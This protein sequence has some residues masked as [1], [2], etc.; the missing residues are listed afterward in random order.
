[1]STA[2]RDPAQPASRLP[3]P[4]QPMFMP[5]W[6]AWIA[7]SWWSETL[8]QARTLPPDIHHGDPVR[9]V[10]PL[11]AGR[12][13]A[14]LAEAAVYTIGWASRGTPLPYWR[15]FAWIASLSTVDLLAFSLRRAAEHGVPL[16]RVLAL[17]LTGPTALDAHAATGWAAAFGAVGVLALLRVAM[18]AWAAALGTGRPITRTLPV[19]AAAWLLTRLVALF[20]FDLLKGMSPVS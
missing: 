17:V 11:L 16:V 20:S 13:S 5:V 19:V 1:M 7:W 8:I 12:A 15:F 18:T 3:W 2:F 9:L 6:W 4:F 14:L 10:A